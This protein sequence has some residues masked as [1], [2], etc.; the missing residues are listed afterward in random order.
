M[1]KFVTIAILTGTLTAISLIS[2]LTNTE[3]AISRGVIRLHVIAH[4]DTKEEQ[5]LKLS[6]RDRILKEGNDI[7]GTQSDKEKIRSLTAANL[8][9]FKRAAADEI[10]KNGYEHPV[11]VTFG[12]CDFPEKVYGDMCLPAGSYEAL[13]VKIGSAKGHNWWC[14]MFPPLCFVN[15]SCD[16]T[17]S[18]TKNAMIDNIGKDAFEMISTDKPKIKFKVYEWWKEITK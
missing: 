16:K 11:E 6:V 15:E 13:V 14:V 2:T 12:K 9:R 4:D 3:E 18:E 1:K 8:N 10:R 7:Y 17:T 5:S